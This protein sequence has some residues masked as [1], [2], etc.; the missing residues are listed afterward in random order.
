LN[1]LGS[2]GFVSAGSQGCR[3][4]GGHHLMFATEHFVSIILNYERVGII[5]QTLLD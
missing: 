4:E 2:D 1:V 5:G 3:C